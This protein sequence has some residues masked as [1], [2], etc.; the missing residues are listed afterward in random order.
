MAIPRAQATSPPARFKARLNLLVY[1]SPEGLR[2]AMAD[3]ID[4]YKYRRYHEGIKNV[5]PS[6]VFFGRRE[7]ILK[8]RDKQ[9]RPRS[10]GDFDTIWAN[11]WGQVSVARRPAG[12]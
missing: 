11:H 1:T 9:N 7:A 12:R 8:R 6:D 2:A 5:T 4:F 10:I 3:F